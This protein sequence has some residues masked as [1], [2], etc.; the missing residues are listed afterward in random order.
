MRSRHA[1]TWFSTTLLWAAIVLHP[2]AWVVDDPSAL[3]QQP[4]PSADSAVDGTDPAI[5]MNRAMLHYNRA[6]KAPAKNIWTAEYQ[7]CI[8]LLTHILEQ[9]PQN[10]S[11]RF[12]RALAHGQLGALHQNEARI[13]RAR[14]EAP[15][16]AQEDSAAAEQY[17][18]MS[19]DIDELLQKGIP[20]RESALHLIDGVVKIKLAG[21]AGGSEA[22][23]VAARTELLGQARQAFEHYLRSQPAP[24]GINRVRG[25]FFLG[26]VVY[27]QALRPADKPD[28]P[29]ELADRARLDEAGQLMLALVR[30]DSAK[31]IDKLLPPGTPDR[32]LEVRRW[33]SYPTLY[34][35]LIRTRQG[36]DEATKG[37]AEYRTY[38]AEAK[39]F[40]QQAWQYDTGHPYPQGEDESLGRLIPDVAK[41]HVPAIEQAMEHRG[42]ATEDLYLDWRMGFAYDTNV[43]LLGHDTSPPPEIGRKRDVRFDT[44]VA[45]GYTLDLAKISPDLDR[46]TVGVSGRSGANWHGD[47]HQFNEQDYGGS[48]AL[49]YKLLQPWQNDGVAQGPLYAGIQYDYDYFLLGNNGFLRVNRL[50]PRLALYTF[51]QRSASTFSFRYEDRNYLEPLPSNGFDR[52]GNYFAFTFSQ[53]YELVD[54]THFYKSIGWEPWGLAYDPADPATYDEN[55]PRQDP[56]NY[57]RWLRPYIGT[58]YGWDS[59]SGTE[60]DQNRYLLAAGIDVPLPY[61]VNFDFGAEWEWQNYHNASLID[62]HR[63]ERDDLVQRYRFGLERQFVLVPGDRANRYT[64]KIDRVMMALRADVQLIYDDSNVE[65]RLG[66][67]VFSY[68]R[69]IYG[70]S[71]ALQFN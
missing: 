21:Y 31:H 65:D 52:D 70:L 8:N 12:M 35:G 49:Q 26:V 67:E 57:Q 2:G 3:A 53:S 43:I 63:R 18:L 30:P 36:T 38:Y 29:D 23:R 4:A 1:R 45:I 37:R 13:D 34:L 22:E 5:L 68:N 27:R 46:W 19:R 42:S 47:I 10:H 54:M 32:D 25:E 55:D 44:G 15:A 71:L 40:F 9:D 33:L 62:Y 6:G 24:T 48:V 16:A 51:D 69:A 60:F 39:E 11:A 66:Q 14:K 20:D 41:E 28:A 50:T 56:N 58:E 7:S 61:G 59:T 64:I 17:R